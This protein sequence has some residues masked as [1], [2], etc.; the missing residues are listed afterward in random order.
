[1]RKKS[2]SV[3]NFD[4]NFRNFA[5]I[6]KKTMDKANG[7]GLAAPQVGENIRMFIIIYEYNTPN[8]KTLYVVNPEILYH[9]EETFVD[10]EGCLS[11]PKK[12]EKI[13]RW[14]RIKVKFQDLDGNEI[15]MDLEGLNA[16]EFQHEFDHLDGILFIDR[17]KSFI[18]QMN[19]V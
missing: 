8:Q 2:K 7:L 4:S 11:L 3:K 14:K 18:S 16:R 15:I 9:S 5:K 19:E 10:E 17:I 1:M 6:M 13:E 12:F